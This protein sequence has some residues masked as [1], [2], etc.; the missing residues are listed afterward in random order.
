MKERSVISR[1]SDQEIIDSI[2]LGGSIQER[3]IHHLFDIHQGFI[4]QAC[5]RHQLSIEDARDAFCDALVALRK[6][7]LAQKFRGESKISTYLYRIFTNKCIDHLRKKNSYHAQLTPEIPEIEDESGNIFHHLVVQEDF[8]YAVQKME[9]I[10]ETCKRVL[11]DSLYYRY[12]MEEVAERAGLPDA[13]TASDRK[14]KCL[15][16]LRKLIQRQAPAR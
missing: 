2:L 12:S 14:Y 3:V 4:G 9:E 8:N 1:Y 10:G 5:E 15:Q 6:Q 16:R 7:I 13:K 11:I